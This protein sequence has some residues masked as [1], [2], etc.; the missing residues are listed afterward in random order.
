MI[1]GRMPL[2]RGQPV[3]AH[4]VAKRLAAASL[5]ERD[6]DHQ[7]RIALRARIRVQRMLEGRHH[8]HALVAGEDVLGA[9]AVMH[10]EVDDGDPRRAVRLERVR[11]ADGDV[12]EEAETHRP[13]AL[14][15]MP[16]R[17]HRAECAAAVA[18]HH[19]V[20]G[21]DQRAGGVQRRGQR[22]GAHRGVGIDVV[23]ARGR[24]FRLD[25]R[26]VSRAVHARELVALRR[27]RRVMHEVAVESGADQAIA[28]R[29]QPVGALGVIRPHVVQQRRRVGDVG[30][31]HV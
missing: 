11:R 17:P 10:V 5:R 8:Q 30:G 7:R 6:V 29:T 22:I 9:V 21:E 1:S 25:R 20:R 3:L 24:R 14:R 2:E 16:G 27:R 12:V 13:V 4:R 28:D 23:Q 26:D 19:E 31:G 18:A 15:M